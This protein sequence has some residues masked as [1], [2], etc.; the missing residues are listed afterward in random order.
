M[1][2]VGVAM[3]CSP[4][5]YYCRSDDQDLGKVD[6]IPCKEFVFPP[7]TQRGRE[8]KDTQYHEDD[9]SLE[10]A[11]IVNLMGVTCRTSRG[12]SDQRFARFPGA[13]VVLRVVLELHLRPSW[14]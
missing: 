2:S 12:N 8:N 1:T 11:R 3:V 14:R 10:H 9:D 5:K 6:F 7:A 13:T 4:M